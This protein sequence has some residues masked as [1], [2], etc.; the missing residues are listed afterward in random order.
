MTTLPNPVTEELPA[1]SH[2]P[3]EGSAS[4]AQ[5]RLAW[6]AV[7]TI[8]WL[9]L[10]LWARSNSALLQSDLFVTMTAFGFFAALTMWGP[11]ALLERLAR[12]L[13]IIS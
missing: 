13:G 7:A 2:F 6:S 8:V 1:R 4:L 9:L 11:A 10:G 12:Y 3:L 5:R